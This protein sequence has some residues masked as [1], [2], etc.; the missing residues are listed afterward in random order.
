MARQRRPHVAAELRPAAAEVG[1]DGGRVAGTGKRPR[2]R[3]RSRPAQR[4]ERHRRRPQADHAPG[5]E[6]ATGHRHHPRRAAADH[7]LATDAS[8][9]AGLGR[10][11]PQPGEARPHP[12]RVERL[13]LQR[14][15]G[16]V[17]D[18]ALV[19]VGGG[20]RR[21]IAAVR[22]VGGAQQQHPLPRHRERD[23]ATLERRGQRRP[24]AVGAVQQQVSALRQQH[25]GAGRRR[26]QPPHRVHPR[27]G[28]VDHG[29]APPPK[30]PRRSGGRPARRRPRGRVRCEAPPPPRTAPPPPPARPPPATRPESAGH[31]G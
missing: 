26:L 13:R 23:A 9:R 14:T 19:G 22:L 18:L 30:A 31:R 17:Q 5:G 16:L 21:R 20:H 29:A 27:P 1:L 11:H 8:G 28:R 15:G 3:R 2:L 7:R 6:L 12:R 25:A 24:P 10:Q 4:L